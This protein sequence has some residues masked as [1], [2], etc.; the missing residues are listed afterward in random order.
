MEAQ[1][2]KEDA[3][4]V[5]NHAG[6]YAQTFYKL[7]LV[8]LTK[9]VSDIASGVV[10]SVLIFFISLCILLFMSFA[11][12][13]WLGDVLNN[14]ALGFLLIAAFYMLLVVILILMRKKVISPFIRNT[15]IS[16][17]YEEKNKVVRGS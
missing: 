15:L 11:G 9:K 14:R 10:N 17:I 16:K 7:S 8:R 6:D 5:L 3:K 4:D 1:N 12:A 13:W 2:L